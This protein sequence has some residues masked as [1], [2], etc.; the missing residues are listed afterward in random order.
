MYDRF[1]VEHKRPQ[2]YGTQ[3]SRINMKS[4]KNDWFVWPIRDPKR[5]N[6]LRKKAGFD[7]TVEDNAKGLGVQ[8]K[9][10]KMSE[11]KIQ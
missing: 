11:I 1:L 8:Y 7:L 6:K 3:I 4:G 10:I 9:V 5:V 2:I